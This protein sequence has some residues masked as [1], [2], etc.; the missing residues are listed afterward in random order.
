MLSGLKKLVSAG[1]SQCLRGVLRPLSA[2]LIA[3]NLLSLFTLTARGYTFTGTGCTLAFSKGDQ[4]FFQ[5]TVSG[6]RIGQL[7]GRTLPALHAPQTAYAA[8]VAP[9]TLQLWHERLNHRALDAVERAVQRVEGL[10][11]NSMDRPPHHCPAC[12]AGKQHRDPFPASSSRASRPLELVHTDLSGPA[13]VPGTGGVLY[14]LT[15]TDDFTCW[16]WLKLITNKREE[17]ILEAFK[18]YK[19]MAEVQHPACRLVTIRDDKGAEFIGK[20]IAAWRKE[21]GI[22][23]QHTVRATPEQNGRAERGF[24][25]LAEG[26][27]CILARA[28]MAVSWWAEAAHAANYVYNR[29]PHRALRRAPFELWYGRKPNL[30]NLRVWGC[31]AYVHLQKDQREEP[32]HGAHTRLCTFIAYRDDYKGWEFLDHETGSRVV[33]RDVLWQ[34][35]AFRHKPWIPWPEQ[36]P[37]LQPPAPPQNA[38]AA[39]HPPADPPLPPFPDEDV[40]DL[41]GDNLPAPAPAPAAPVHPADLPAPPLRLFLQPL[42]HSMTTLGLLPHLQSVVPPANALSLGPS[43]SAMRH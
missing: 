9:L 32:K 2:S 27:T 12:A 29:F 16:R 21:H 19:A 41:G 33:S 25:D 26:A 11:I 7:L 1:L 5:A 35:N 37:M 6:R 14:R 24:R 15:I 34:E 28:G 20:Q 3:S 31:L 40:F 13:R 10:T 38:P 30:A 17:T 43:G 36:H 23:A 39:P 42:Q 18:E 22:Q 8:A 4:V